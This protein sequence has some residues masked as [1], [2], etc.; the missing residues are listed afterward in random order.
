MHIT[1]RCARCS[2]SASR[3]CGDKARGRT[4]QMDFEPGARRWKKGN[5]IIVRRNPLWYPPFH[6]P[7]RER[8]Y[9]IS[10]AY[11]TALNT[12]LNLT[13]RPPS[14]RGRIFTALVEPDSFASP[15]ISSPSP[16]PSLLYRA[17]RRFSILC[18]R[19]HS[20]RNGT[21]NIFSCLCFF[22]LF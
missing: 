5:N 22:S 1:Y 13:A 7:S 8:T 20:A 4:G 3:P 17:D 10:I 14:V 19:P 11:F 15:R 16:S 18:A 2:S 12:S 9:I 6:P 21:G